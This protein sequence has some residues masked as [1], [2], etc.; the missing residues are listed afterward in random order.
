MVETKS[1]LKGECICKLNQSEGQNN[2]ECLQLFTAMGIIP[3]FV[4]LHMNYI[5]DL[6]NH[7]D[8]ILVVNISANH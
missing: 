4:S 2:S 5:S 3:Y 1:K 7:Q 6:S 8:N